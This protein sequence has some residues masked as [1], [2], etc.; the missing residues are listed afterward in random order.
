MPFLDVQRLIHYWWVFSKF[1]VIKLEFLKGIYFKSTCHGALNIPADVSIFLD[2][3]LETQGLFP[4]HFAFH[5]GSHNRKAKLSQLIL[6]H[7]LR[8]DLDLV[9]QR[10]TWYWRNKCLAH[11]G[12]KE[13][14]TEVVFMSICAIW[15]AVY[16]L[17]FLFDFHVALEPKMIWHD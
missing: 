17:F 8:G 10:Q 3:T 13:V 7:S 14:Q 1:L 4:S 16:V 15:T 2:K 9:N 6:A 5:T 12:I 11:A